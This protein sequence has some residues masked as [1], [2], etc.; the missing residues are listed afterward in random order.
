MLSRSVK[1][2]WATR[3]LCTA[4]LLCWILEITH[5]FG[6]ASCQKPEDRPQEQHSEK[7]SEEFCA[8]RESVAGRFTAVQMP[9]NLP[10]D[11]GNALAV[12]GFAHGR[13]PNDL[14]ESVCHSRKCRFWF[15]PL[16]Q[17]ASG[18]EVLFVLWSTLLPLFESVERGVAGPSAAA[19]D[20]LETLHPAQVVERVLISAGRPRTQQ[21]GL[22]HCLW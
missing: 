2:V 17:G 21:T 3:W 7:A 6:V 1:L 8:V 19:G 4:L 13:S 15:E 20:T 9:S 22:D 11:V 5:S 18:R 12:L 14:P 16:R 10:L